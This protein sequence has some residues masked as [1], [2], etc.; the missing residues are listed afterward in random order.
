MFRGFWESNLLT[1]EIKAR[2]NQKLLS[3]AVTVLCSGSLE[4]QILF[5]TTF[6]RSADSAGTILKFINDTKQLT[7][8]K[9]LGGF[10]SAPASG[11]IQASD[12]KLYGMST[13]GG[14]DNFGGIFSYDPVSDTYA[15]LNS[16]ADIN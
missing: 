5:G 8:L 12:G 13:T 10:G 7:V 11:L 3:I 14:V 6:G 1:N 4:S 16:L 9:S 2:M 15:V